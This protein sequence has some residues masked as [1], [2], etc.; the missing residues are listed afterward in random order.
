M[1][2]Y[3]DGSAVLVGDCVLIENGRTEATV[4]H[5]VAT[6]EQQRE[7]GVELPGVMLK[8]A[9]FGLLYLPTEFLA[10]EPLRFVSRA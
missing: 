10:D 9:P 7:W 3:Q 1:I 4:V 6:A 5:V 8:S 2:E